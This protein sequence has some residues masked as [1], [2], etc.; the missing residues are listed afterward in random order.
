MGAAI[1]ES[2]K[3]LEKISRVSL[4]M[5]NLGNETVHDKAQGW[6]Q[7]I[8]RHVNLD[9]LRFE[10]LHTPKLSQCSTGHET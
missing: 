2:V 9:L 5:V 10:Y 8:L 6:R 7:L 4:I 1:I 3:I